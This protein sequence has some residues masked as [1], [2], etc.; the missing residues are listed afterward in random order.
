MSKRTVYKMANM[1]FKDY[2]NSQDAVNDDVPYWCSS[3]KWDKCDNSHKKCCI[4]TIIK[5][6]SKH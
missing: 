3:K 1:I 6:Y 5:W 2:E 4:K